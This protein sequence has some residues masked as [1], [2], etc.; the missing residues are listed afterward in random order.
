[1]PSR[2]LRAAVRSSVSADV[3]TRGESYFQRGRVSILNSS[4][5][6]L[7]ASVKGTRKYQVTLD[8][9]EEELIVSCTCPY[10]TDVVAPCKHVWA[11]ILAADE[12][13]AFSVPPT[14]RLTV[15][16][17]SEDDLVDDVDPDDWDDP[18]DLP[19]EMWDDKPI[20]HRTVRRITAA[21]RR[22]VS[23]RMKRY[24]AERRRATGSARPARPP[25]PPRPE[26]PPA[27]PPPPAWQSFLE[28][29][30][31]SPT[32]VPVART[33]LAGDV[34]Y[35]IDLT[36]S[37]QTGV[38]ALDVMTRERKKNGEW[39][40]PK[41]V[42]LTTRQLA[43][44]TDT[45]DREV[46]EAAAG[47]SSVSGG[48]YQAMTGPYDIPISSNLIL[49]ATLQRQVTP[50]VAATGRCLVREVVPPAGGVVA[51]SIAPVRTTT[52]WRPPT[53][54]QEVLTEVEW[55]DRVWE[56]WINI[57]LTDE[58]GYAIDAV[59][60][61]GDER[62]PV[63][64]AALMTDALVLWTPRE[65]AVR[66]LALLDR[67]NADRW[68]SQLRERGPIVVPATQAP[69]LVEAIA[70][71][72]LRHV[73]CPD[74]L[75][76]P[77]I[78]EPPQ[79]IV[80]VT[81]PAHTGYGSWAA[82]RLDAKLAFG[83][84]GIEIEA[85]ATSPVVFD[86]ARRAAI[87]R[88]RE[89]EHAAIARLQGLGVRRLADWQK[90]GTR[91]DM[92]DKLLPTLV[93]VLLREG[94]R[95]EA[96]GR[97]YRR[98][99]AMALAVRS[100]I[101][102]FE[103]HGQVDFEGVTAD[104]PVLLAAVRRGDTFVP[105]GDGTFGL[106]PEDWLSRNGGIAA[107]GSPV[108]DHVRFAASQ[109]GLL[110]AWL[111]TQPAVTCDEMFARARAELARFDGVAPADPVA[112]FRGVL[113]DYQRDALGWFNFLRRFRFGGCL[114]DDMGLGKTVMVLAM[115]EARRLEAD[116]LPHGLGESQADRGL[117]TSLIV[118]PRSLVFNWKQ[119]AARFGPELRILDYTGGGRHDALARVTDYDIVLTTY[120]T[121][122]RD[123]GQLRE[124]AFN[125]VILDEAQVVKNA[126]TSAAKSVRLLQG[127]H[128]LALSGTP[129]ENHLGELWSLFDFLNP[130][131]LGTASVFA[132]ATAMVGRGRR[133]PEAQHEDEPNRR[134]ALAL[135]ARGL[136][137]FILRRTKEQVASEL[138]AR[139]E[140]TIYCDLEPPQR[141]LY[142]E[143]R[144]HYR[145]TLLST[146]T[147]QGLGRAKLQVL[148]ALLRLRQA[149]CHPG[150]IDK[151][152]RTDPSA[153]LDLLVPRVEELVEDGRK[154]LI[155]SQFTSLLALL[156][157]KL[158]A[159]Q[160]GYEY[161][162]GQTRDREAR[163]RRFQE[164]GCPLFLVSLKAGGLGLN[165]T[166]A[167]YVFLLDP[168]WNPA[169]EAQAIDRAHRIGQTRPVF[170]YRLIARDTVEEKVL[171]LQ[172]TKRALADAILRA[173]GVGI[174]DLRREDLE[175]LL[176]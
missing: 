144:D 79:P 164:D 17:D 142:N 70:A 69:A 49:N 100:G 32:G 27:P 143:L 35:V 163:V 139:T 102:W 39:A 114:A 4:D 60:R 66:R 150:L 58:G 173:D 72:D 105:L 159:A 131:M 118:V 10:F 22:S 43:H 147:R 53:P 89:R 152:R 8:L 101:D 129:V 2:T 87:R 146:T 104:L 21:M 156:R 55:D 84:A 113:R 174:R 151:Q 175:L 59:L 97:L 7:I 50:R 93:R 14:V 133:R 47:A 103:L 124:L 48:A 36:R 145:A 176:S 96:E 30:G 117:R 41:A 33:L 9:R 44:L 126:R 20:E 16:D 165:L 85:D 90:G 54:P 37:I 12:A 161:L 6:S 111:A 112:S 86:G 148:E 123:A 40:K 128:R 76:I 162:D 153:K 78:T 74:D 63:S 25:R 119:E 45:R 108:G 83:Y 11:T 19:G 167:E 71:A 120:G 46:L 95:V 67:G 169:V 99:G 3:R 172:S 31:R 13:R 1:M 68:V 170:V 77:E 51:R 106:L 155:F 109:A 122:R 88:D 132:D 157:S 127:R 98:A 110:D 5:G 34:I 82:D 56:L 121:L 158:E 138:P 42:H 91:L 166:A 15:P 115:L 29:I 52:P 65:D 137:P 81:R 136:R 116:S 160:L 62:R 64:D 92:A 130:G 135:L 171:D 141:A 61:A 94:W 75:R 18:H 168:W 28:D 73:E 149:A 154:V 140:Q 134:E 26:P 38:L 57:V 24:W 23:E 125:Y 107:L 80:R